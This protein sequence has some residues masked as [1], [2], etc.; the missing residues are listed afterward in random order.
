[1]EVK[2]LSQGDLILDIDTV[3]NYIR[4]NYSIDDSLLDVYLIRSAQDF[5]ERTL[6]ITLSE[7]QFAV[8]YECW[9]ERIE[10]PYGPHI[11]VEDVFEVVRGVETEIDNWYVQGLDF[12][13]LFIPPSYAS[14]ERE[15]RG[16]KV[17]FTA[18]YL[19]N[20]DSNPVELPASLV[21]GML[22]VI[23]TNYEYRVNVGGEQSM[24]MPNDA[25][26]L[27]KP[28]KRYHW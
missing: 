21:E 15:Q 26:N 4:T 16:I 7:T 1:M 13:T 2:K 9:K 5:V 6:E 10:L 20:D 23:A 19:K 28:Y 17:I 24:F 27:M 11:E 14:G 22:K 3:K 12:K 18:G 25:M 8:Y